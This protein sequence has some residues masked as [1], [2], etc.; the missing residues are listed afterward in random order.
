MTMLDTL[1][2]L[3][4]TGLEDRVLPWSK[5]IAVIYKRVSGESQAGED[6][7]SLFTQEKEIREYI[8]LKN[9]RLN[10]IYEDV[11]SG[12]LYFEKR[13]GGKRLLE[14]ATTGKFNVVI[15]WDYDRL[16]RDAEGLAAKMFRHQM[17]QLGIQIFSLHQPREIKDP[18]DYLE[19]PYDDG[20]ILLENIHDWQSAS[21]VSKFRV[22]SMKAKEERAKKGK[23]LNTPPYGYMLEPMRTDKGEIIVKKD[24][25]V[26]YMRVVNEIEKNIVIR[27]YNEYS[28]QGKSMN[29]IRDSLNNDGV[30]ARKGGHWER[31]MVA[32]ILK[33]PVYYGAL[34]YNR[35]FRRKNALTGGTKWGNNPSEKWI[36]VSPDQTEHDAIVSKEIFD[37]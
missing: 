8:N 16:G 25:R 26:V 15:V 2:S 1:I 22:R 35:H 29:E 20:E 11:I 36:V 33:N 9:W 7:T 31:A 32:R 6:K 5:F 14:D 13:I 28:Y 12:G 37:K 27:I 19:N 17:R 21:T 3:N 30:C 34:I 23:M 18:K 4:E 10:G 24:G